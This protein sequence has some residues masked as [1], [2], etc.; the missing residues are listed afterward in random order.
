MEQTFG[1][2]D[3]FDAPPGLTF[4]QCGQTRLMLSRPESAGQEKASILY[5]DVP[6]ARAAGAALAA[7]GATMVEEARCIA[8]VGAKD[9]WF[10][11]A[12]DGEGNLLGLMSEEQAAA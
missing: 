3:L 12:A 9:I 5:Y 8:R 2:P 1:L 6:D 7:E 10:A 11:I 4:F